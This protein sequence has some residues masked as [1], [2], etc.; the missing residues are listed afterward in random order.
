MRREGS[1][2]R[3]MRKLPPYWLP[4]IWILR[5]LADQKGSHPY[6]GKRGA[7]AATMR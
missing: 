4:L 3:T 5:S 2:R 7:G 6:E 1:S